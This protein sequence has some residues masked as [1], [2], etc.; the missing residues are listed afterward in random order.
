MLIAAGV[1]LWRMTC[2]APAWYA[3]PDAH[4]PQIAALADK[5]ENR[6]LEEAQKVRTDPQPWTLRVRESQ[7]NAWLSAR[8][9][10][11]IA[12]EQHSQWPEQLGTP[13]VKIDSQGISLAVPV[14]T[15]S[16]SRYIAARIRPQLIDG[17]LKLEI[18]RVAL[19]RVVLPGE[20]LANLLRTLQGAVPSIAEDQKVRSALEILAGQRMV[21]PVTRL[22]DH[23]KLRLLNLQLGDG[24]VDLTAQTLDAGELSVAPGP[25]R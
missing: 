23:R 8:L 12:H 18:D 10:Q 25:G 19:G 13:Q 5:V 24:W 17:R 6:M 9:P 14:Q 20:P 3:L 4:D 2:I 22:A 7:I 21:D 16:R 1:V 11:W 15:G